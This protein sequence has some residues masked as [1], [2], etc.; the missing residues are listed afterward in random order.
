MAEEY[1]DAQLV[2]DQ[3][4]N[5]S[6]AR[7]QDFFYAT[8]PAF[9][10]LAAA[11]PAPDSFASALG[12]VQFYAI[13]QKPNDAVW[14]AI[15]N[16]NADNL[17]AMGGLVYDY[18]HKTYPNVN[19]QKLDIKTW[20]RVVENIPDL[21]VGR[22]V[23][24]TWKYSTPGN[25]V[26]GAFLSMIANTVIAEGGTLLTDFTSFLNSI[27]DVVF[28][29]HRPGTTYTALI[30]TISNFLIQNGPSCSDYGAI[31]IRQIEFA[32]SFVEL[33]GA[34]STTNNIDI[35][36]SYTEIENKVQTNRIR[37][38]G[39]DHENFTRL[40][41]S[42]ATAQFLKAK[43]LFNKPAVPQNELKPAA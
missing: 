21:S 2:R 9:A 3:E 25:R 1:L 23:L 33:K 29:V 18:M 42:N 27:G 12:N 4:A 20:A 32:E 40:V 36:V 8:P 14:S 26:P 34:C 22:P 30:F 24:K 17:L 31:T 37:Q 19:S 6:Y 28:S 16:E 39:P 15:M 41:N 43:N 38:G 10:S 35:N 7:A 11:A 5:E 13:G